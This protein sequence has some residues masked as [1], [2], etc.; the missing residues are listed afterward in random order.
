MSDK[1]KLKVKVAKIK[2]EIGKM[3]KDKNNPFF[4]SQY[5]DINAILENLKPLEEAHKISITAPLTNVNGLPA[6]ALVI[7]DLEA[8]EQIREVTMLPQN[9]D[10]QKM[11]SSITYFRRYALVSYFELQAEDDD[12][13]KG[14]SKEP[15]VK[16]EE[17]IVAIELIE[18]AKDIDS[19]K[20]IFTGLTPLV[21]KQKRVVEAKDKKKAEL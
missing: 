12:G 3:S 21:R 9:N 5:F 19:L 4:K 14:A 13:N 8:D 17:V 11:G 1:L 2:S 18:S 16:E 15:E 20:A 7:D 6:I 10:P